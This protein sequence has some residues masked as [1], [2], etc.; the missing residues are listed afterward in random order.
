MGFQFLRSGNKLKDIL[1]KE[2]IKNLGYDVNEISYRIFIIK[3]LLKKEEVQE[4]LSQAI[5]ASEEEWT[6]HYM[7]GVRELAR[8]KF[9]REDIDNLVKEGL[10]EITHNWND[11][12]LAI[13][14][15]KLAKK[16]DARCQE[17]FNF[18]NDLIFNGCG[19]IQRQYEGVPLKSHIDNHTDNSLEYAAVFYLNNNYTDGEVYFVDQGIQLKP[20]P[21]DALVFPAV[22]GWEHG[23]NAPGPGPHRYIIPTFISRKN[24]WKINEGNHYNLDKTLRDTDL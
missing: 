1:T 11:K 12:N 21:G 20:D 22:D 4:I 7:E 5:N 18:R 10:Y 14:N 13:S 19:T 17:I 6:F 3:N 9:G 24:F 15:K 16:I 8:L 2:Y 23:V